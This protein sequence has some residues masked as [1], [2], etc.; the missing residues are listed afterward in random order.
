MDT[1]LKSAREKGFVETLYKRRRRTKNLHSSN[2]NMVQAEERAAINMPIQGTAADIIKIAMINIHNRMA[3][4]KVNSLMTLQIHDE[5]LFECPGD[6]VEAMAKMVVE[7]M[8][9]A[10]QLTVPLKV[11]WNYGSSWFDAH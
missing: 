9:G 5:L 6:E 4:E 2:W 8:E 10:A 7:E 1:T 3:K 11:D